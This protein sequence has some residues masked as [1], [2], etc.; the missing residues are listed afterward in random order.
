MSPQ[1]MTWHLDALTDIWT[2]GAGGSASRLITTGLLGSI[3]WWF[4]VVIRGLGGLACDPTAHGCRDKTHCVVCELFGCTG[5]ARKFRFDVLDAGG[6]CRVRE[7]DGKRLL[8]P[9]IN[10]RETFKLRF[11][12]LRP[13]GPKEWALLAVTIRLIA[14]YGAIGG[15]T[16][17]KPS[18]ESHR[19]D[20]DHHRDFGLVRLVAVPPLIPVSKADL[21]SFVHGRPRTSDTWA[22]TKTMWCVK[23]RYLAR[24]TTTASSFNRVVGRKESKKCRDCGAVHDPPRKCSQTRRQTRRQPRRDSERLASNKDRFSRWLAGGRGESKK[25]FSFKEPARTF[26]FVRNDR[27][28]VA[29][30][31]RLAEVWGADGFTAKEFLLGG[32]ILDE[33]LGSSEA[34]S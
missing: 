24:E 5:W 23:N 22:S 17:L 11:T 27:E 10:K 13:I 25:V 7:A 6:L 4:E 33:I 28:L 1:S 8:Q 21:T 34:A 2:G 29:V 18:R 16:V 9:Q 3:R 15:K 19:A 20:K 26:G 14:D 30:R 32:D 31:T 12:P